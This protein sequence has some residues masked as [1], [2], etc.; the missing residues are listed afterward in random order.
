[1]LFRKQSLFIIFSL[2]SLLLSFFGIDLVISDI[3]T[4]NWALELDQE[5]VLYGSHLIAITLNVCFFIFLKKRSVQKKI[6]LFTI[7]WLIVFFIMYFLLDWLLKGFIIFFTI[8]VLCQ[9]LAIKF[10]KKD[11]D[12]IKSVDRIR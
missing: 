4:K 11:D 7:V 6:L 8:S 10:I 5:V 3:K 2:I 9:I 12:L 1:M